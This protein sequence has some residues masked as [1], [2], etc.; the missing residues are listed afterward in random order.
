MIAI[1]EGCGSN[2][3]SVQLA[4]ERLGYASI[5]THDK[6][7]ISQASHV[8]LPGVGHAR[9][10]MET[11]KSLDLIN[12]IKT[13]KQPV[14]GI[15]LGMQLLYENMEEGNVDG[16]GIIPGKVERL[17][18]DDRLIYPHMGWNTVVSEHYSE[19][20]YFVHTYA[21]PVNQYTVAQTVY[22]RPFTAI[23]AKDNYVGM[24]FHPE[25]SG[26]FG[27][28]WLADFLNSRLI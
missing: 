14:L 20:A 8:I 21:A 9:R 26:A 2:I 19:Y 23:V 5:L 28:K 22:G 7:E 24:Q 18:C 15:C 11:L 27:E 13:L 16:L 4:L 10:A 17:S 12:C 1:I 25:I 6:V 3:A